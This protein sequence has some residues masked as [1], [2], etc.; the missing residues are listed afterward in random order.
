MTEK[1]NQNVP[2]TEEMSNQN[3]NIKNE[4]RQRNAVLI[5]QQTKRQI[6][7]WLEGN[8]Y[9]ELLEYMRSRVMGQENIAVV[10]ANVQQ[11]A[12][13]YLPNQRAP[14]QC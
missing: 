12:D 13:K 4:I 14:V 1:V 2:K 9:Q 8:P 11:F 5:D 10:V 6:Q 7:E 3:N